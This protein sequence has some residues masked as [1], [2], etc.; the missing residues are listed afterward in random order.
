MR[1]LL[2]NAYEENAKVLHFTFKEVSDL[3]V[4]RADIQAMPVVLAQNMFTCWAVDVIEH[5]MLPTHCTLSTPWISM[6]FS[7]NA[8]VMN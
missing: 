5:L 7:I 3:V 8:T 2:P 6:S 1:K 4:V